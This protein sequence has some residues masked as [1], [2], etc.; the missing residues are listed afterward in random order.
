MYWLCVGCVLV[1]DDV[2]VMWYELC[3]CWLVIG[4]VGVMC[5]VSVMYWLVSGVALVSVLVM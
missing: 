4:D 2:L 5:Y 1:I 3:I